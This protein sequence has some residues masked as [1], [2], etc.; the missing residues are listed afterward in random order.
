MNDGPPRS[1]WPFNGLT[2]P[3]HSALHHWWRTWQGALAAEDAYETTR[4]HGAPRDVAA[5][6]AFKALTGGDLPIPPEFADGP[7]PSPEALFGCEDH[8]VEPT[9]RF[10]P[11]STA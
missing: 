9:E 11:R 6:T 8:K 5:D 4:T 1:R 2:H 7:Q 10:A 3:L